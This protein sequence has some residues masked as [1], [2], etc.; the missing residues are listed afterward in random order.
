MMNNFQVFFNVN[1][2]APLEGPESFFFPQ[3]LLDAPLGSQVSHPR[4]R[5]RTHGRN[6]MTGAATASERRLGDFERVV[7]LQL[8]LL[9]EPHLAS[10]GTGASA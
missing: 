8:D 9:L 2:R 7:V 5:R 6:Q 1:R 4:R 3:R 10:L